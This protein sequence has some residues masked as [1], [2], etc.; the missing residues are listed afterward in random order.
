MVRSCHHECFCNNQRYIRRR[1]RRRKRRKRVS[2]ELHWCLLICLCRRVASAWK[3]ERDAD[4]HE[5]EEHNEHRWVMLRLS[6]DKGGD[7]GRRIRTKISDRIREL[8]SQQH[9]SEIVRIQ[10]SL[11]FSCLAF[12]EPLIL[13]APQMIQGMED[14][15][16]MLLTDENLWSFV[17][18]VGAPDPT[19]MEDNDF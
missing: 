1:R 6:K 3:D 14:V 16:K 9:L 15:S 17:T 13:M 4:H 11:C 5:W 2:L 18:P 7:S 8:S 12:H 19:P 10:I